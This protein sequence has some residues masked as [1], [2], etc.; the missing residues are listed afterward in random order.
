[1]DLNTY[2]QQVSVYGGGG[3]GGFQGP[4]G[5]QG[6]SGNIGPASDTP[7]PPG[8]EGPRGYQGDIGVQGSDGQMG[9]QGVEGS[10]GP[11]GV[12]GDVGSQGFQGIVGPTGAAGGGS[13]STPLCVLY[14]VSLA[15]A[16][17]TF[18]P[19]GEGSE[20]IDTD[21]FHS[22]TVNPTRIT[23]TVEGYYQFN[24]ETSWLGGAY[25]GQNMAFGSVKL[26]KNGSMYSQ[27]TG[28][29]VYTDNWY[30]NGSTVAY[31]NGTT[32]YF[33]V[34]VQGAQDS[35]TPP[36]ENNRFSCAFIRSP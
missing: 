7:G 12:I 16:S 29:N 2:Q 10:Q 13:S 22:T 35:A 8:P 19:F 36:F 20:I 17:E 34:Y 3:G 18:L 5:V 25:E 31:A 1:M 28:M 24:F 15:V 14:E 26:Y 23:P 21:G 32:D 6:E 33:E 11:Q 30:L 27:S 4:E 9:V